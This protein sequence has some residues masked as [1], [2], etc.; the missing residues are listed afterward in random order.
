MTHLMPDDNWTAV[1]KKNRAA[2]LNYTIVRIREALRYFSDSRLELFKKIPLMIHVNSPDFPGYVNGAPVCGGIWNFERSGFFREAQ[3]S[4]FVV[5]GTGKIRP[6][7]QGLYHMGSLGTFTQSAGSDF[8]YWV[9]VDKTFTDGRQLEALAEKLKAIKTY[10]ANNYG[11]EVSFFIHDSNDIRENQFNPLLDTDTCIAPKELLK[12]EFYRTFLMIAGKIPLWAVLPTGLS[13]EE[14]DLWKTTVLSSTELP[15]DGDFLDLGNIEGIPVHEVPRG[16]LWH[17]CKSRHDPVKALIKASMAASHSRSSQRPLL[18][19]IIKQGYSSS[20]IDDHS[21][22]P[23]AL[24]FERILEFYA[25]AGD[26]KMSDLIKSAIF[27]RLCGYPAVAMPP[28]GSPKRIILEAYIDRWKLDSVRVSKLLSFQTWSESEK[29]LL[30]NTLIN[31]LGFLYKLAIGDLGTVKDPDDPGREL[32][33]LK[34]KT[35]E[36]LRRENGKIPYCSIYLKRFQYKRF[37]LEQRSGPDGKKTW[38]LIDGTLPKKEDGTKRE[39]F[40]DP[41]LFRAIGWVM[42]NHLYRYAFSSIEMSPPCRMFGSSRELTDFDDLYLF[43]QPWYPLT[44]TL[45]LQQPVWERLL[46]LLVCEPAGQGMDLRSA[47]FLVKNSWGE[48][49][50]DSM[51]FEGIEKNNDKCYQIAMKVKTDYPSYAKVGFYQLARRADPSLVQ[52][53]RHFLEKGQVEHDARDVLSK[54]RPYLDLL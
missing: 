7:V 44:D 5:S 38:S 2:F 29:L 19:D 37:A 40:A 53:T 9:I 4:G 14:Y 8:D 21:V 32:T 45:Y 28:E 42:A 20:G 51:M 15:V 25:E 48:I 46:I 50:F 6:V 10:S 12:E 49:Y 52:Q 33:V 54:K 24:L 17:I 13:N 34:H 11:Q 47:E 43:L 35:I 26:S 27:F 22:D 30:E 31:A 41:H 18:C 23:Y 16:I 39:L 36:F 1:L 3:R